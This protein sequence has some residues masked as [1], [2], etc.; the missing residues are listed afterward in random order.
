ME[1]LT[2]KITLDAP[3]QQVW[4]VLW[5]D[6]TYP[7]WT[8]AFS[9]GSIAETDWKEGSKILFLDGKGHGMVS[10]IAVRR[11]PEFMSFKHLGEVHDGVEDLTSEKVSAWAGAMENYTLRDVNGK[12]ELHIETDVT[13]DFK[14]YFVKTWPHALEKLK[15]IVERSGQEAVTNPS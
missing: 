12:T 13:D 2:F 9:P 6:V 5:S 15:S 14:D 7:E 4:D 11:A 10:T 8:S 3:R 1:K